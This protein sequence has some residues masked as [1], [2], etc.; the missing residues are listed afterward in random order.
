[1][2]YTVAS[3]FTPRGL[4]AADA[5]LS[6]CG[7]H[8]DP[9]VD[10]TCGV[11]DQDDTLCATGSCCGATLRCLAVDDDHRGEGLM[12]MVISH[13]CEV[14]AARGNTHL[15][16]YTKPQSA[17]FFK[18]LGFFE[19]AR[20][21]EVAFLENRKSG[22]SD[23]LSHLQCASAPREQTACVVMNANPFTRGHRYLLETACA[24]A[25]VVHVFVLSENFGPISAATRKE[26]VRLGTA[27]LL[28]VILHDSGPYMISSATFPSYFLKQDQ[29]V[30]QVHARLDIAVFRHIADRLSIGTRYVGEEPFSQVTAMYNQVMAETL[31]EYGIYFH[32]VPRLC[33]S[34]R[35]VSASTVRQALHDEDMRTAHALLCESTWQYLLSPDGRDTL[36][37]I[38]RENDLIH[39]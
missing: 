14:Q 38:R 30:S 8:R 17:G 20:T 36:A 27:D 39:H 13:L 29:Q 22:F 21:D 12:N 2:S 37:A 32:V 31:P 23:W 7:L 6:R 19:I 4:A 18:D 33:L 15:F 3:V 1:M 25:Q 28:K 35:A 34:G 10:Y 16:L 5:L 11:F 9:L 24:N 26:L